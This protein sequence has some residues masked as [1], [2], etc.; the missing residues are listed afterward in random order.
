MKKRTISW[1]L[2]DQKEH[3][4][5]WSDKAKK[6]WHDGVRKQSVKLSEEVDNELLK[7]LLGETSLKETSKEA[8]ASFRKEIDNDIISKMLQRPNK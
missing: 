8:Y 1:S 4:K 7:R 2:D 5:G 3:V 6:G